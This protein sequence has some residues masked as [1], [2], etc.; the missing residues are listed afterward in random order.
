M[1]KNEFQGGPYFEVFSA[2]GKDPIAKWKTGIG[3]NKTFDKEVRS[4]VFCLEGNVS[5]TKMQLP[6]DP[7]HALTLIQRFLVLQLNVPKGQDFSI[8]LGVTDVQSSKMRLVLSTTY[9]EIQPNQLHV[10]IPLG[11]IRRQKWLHLCLDLASLVSET[12]RG[13][14]YKSIDSIC[15]SA[16]CKLRRIYT[17]RHQL[18][19][20][21][22]DE[23]LYD[24]R[25]TNDDIELASVPKQC[26]LA[27][28][29]PQDV[30][31]VTMTKLR[32]YLNQGK[33]L[34]TTTSTDFDLC[35]SGN[36]KSV[37]EEYHI[38]FGTK[39]AGCVQPRKSSAKEGSMSNRQSKSGYLRSRSD[40]VPSEAA[41]ASPYTD[42]PQLVTKPPSAGETP[43][44]RKNSDPGRNV[45]DPEV[46]ID[47]SSLRSSHTWT[48]GA[49]NK[50][51]V[52]FVRPHPPRGPSS[53]RARRRP[54][55]KSAGKS[56]SHGTKDGSSGPSSRV[57]SAGS[58][59]YSSCGSQASNVQSDKS[60]DAHDFGRSDSESEPSSYHTPT[61][62]ALNNSEGDIISALNGHR[63]DEY[64]VTEEELT[65]T[66]KSRVDGVDADMMDTLTCSLLPQT[67]YQDTDEEDDGVVGDRL[68]T[69]SSPPK[70][71][72]THV[73][74]RGKTHGSR[75]KQSTTVISHDTKT[76]SQVSKETAPS[77]VLHLGARP[78]TDFHR[79]I[80]SEDDDTRREAVNTTKFLSPRTVAAEL[81]HVP[82]EHGDGPPGGSSNQYKSPATSQSHRSISKKSL[83]EIPKNDLRLSGTLKQ[84]NS[85]KYQMAD[86]SD[87]FE[88]KMLE[89]LRRQAMEDGTDS[90][91]DDNCKNT[92]PTR[93]LSRFKYGND[94]GSDSSDDTS[95]SKG[96]DKSKQ[97]CHSYQDEMRSFNNGFLTQSNPRDWGNVFSPPIVL[98]SAMQNDGSQ[99]LGNLSAKTDV[100]CRMNSQS[101]DTVTDE[102][103]EL[104]LLYD[105]VLNCYYDPKTCKYYELV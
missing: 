14:T 101:E 80:S 53:D 48:D 43:R 71:V 20:T 94:S 88:A 61:R 74:D 84:Y 6:K 37:Q 27:A 55:V 77:N 81:L 104:D 69:F 97:Q 18:V 31:V 9:R 102:E 73:S 2:Q 82:M 5:T 75:V 87:S 12:W 29:I 105:P 8:D 16:N 96:Q 13:Q 86:L 3:I 79:N 63:E 26:Q 36:R 95:E 45:D 22:D 38:A 23:D 68:Y 17:T 90:D 35:S 64:S 11:L 15:I 76:R 40:P 39:V 24:F 66:L 21:T 92:K 7:K 41:G 1:F 93:S 19:D 83:R 99:D 25:G 46:S 59:I 51:N 52:P 50:D 56:G 42:R 10:K 70:S 100:K 103:D 60:R 34:E 98:P 58:S 89:S 32:C 62:S 54:R 47:K 78:E 30:Q 67:E 85:S 44:E 4:F 28:D 72:R 65:S 57:S 91:S 49:D 33:P